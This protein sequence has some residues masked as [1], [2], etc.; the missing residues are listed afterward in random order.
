ML[1]V[2]QNNE[3]KFVDILNNVLYSSNSL[4]VLIFVIK[5]EKEIGM[6]ITILNS[7]IPYLEDI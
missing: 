7:L 2:I 1:S 5:L 6:F 4:I 3:S